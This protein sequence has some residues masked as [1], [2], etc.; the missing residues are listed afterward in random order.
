MLKVT[1]IEN[2]ILQLGPGE[3]Q[4]FC[5]TF[6]SKKEE[7]G[8]ILG[9]GTKS[10]TSKTTK[11]NPDT[12]FRKDNGKYVFVAY[13]AQQEGVNK[14]IKEDIYKCLDS[15]K[16]GVAIEDI[17]EIVCCH[18]SSTLTAGEDKQLHEYCSN[19]GVTLTFYGVDEIAQEICKQ[20]PTLA[21]DLGISLDTHQIMQISDFIKRYDSNEM[22]APLNTQFLFRQEELIEIENAIQTQNVVVIHGAAG[23]GKTRIAIE[24]SKN[25]ADRDRYTLLCVKS[26][27]LA[28]YEDLI[29]YTERPGKYLFFIDDANE[30]SGLNL[31]LDYINRTDSGYHIKVILTV[32]DYVKE[33]VLKTVYAFASPAMV[34]IKRLKDEDIK[35]FL[36]VNMDIRNENYV[37]QIVRVAEGNLRIA[38]MTG[39]LAIDKAS[40]AAIRD[41]TD[42]YEQYYSAIINSNIWNSRPLSI[43][44]GILALVNAVM[45]DRLD[46]FKDLLAAERISEDEFVDCIRQLSSMELVEVHKDMVAAVSDQ[47][48]ANYMLYYSFF[49]K[50]D[51]P[52]STVLIASF[53]RFKSGVVK[54]MNTLLNIFSKA[55]VHNYMAEEVRIA[56]KSFEGNK[57]PCFEDFARAFHVFQPEA[58]FIIAKEKIDRI[59]QEKSEGK[60][61][62]FK[63]GSIRSGDDILGFLTG[64]NYSPHLKTVFELLIDFAGKSE[65]NALMGYSWLN[66]NYEVNADTIKY[67][68]YAE[69]NLLE[70]IANYTDEN[71][72]V[73]QLILEY[74]LG[75]LSF[76]FRPVSIGRENTIRF[77]HLQ[78]NNSEGVKAYRKGCWNTLMCYLPKDQ[79]RQIIP[80]I[81]RYAKSLRGA[82]DWDIVSDDKPYV[83]CLLAKLQCPDIQKAQIV[84][85]LQYAWI[86][87][88]DDS[89]SDNELFQLDEWKLFS[90]LENSYF[91]ADMS[92]EE[93]EAKRSETLSQYAE[94]L[95]EDQLVAF[96]EL[97][98]RLAADI[99]SS[100]RFCINDGVSQIVNK[101]C[102][103]KSKALIIFQLLMEKGHH[104]EVFPVTLYQILFELLSANEIW[105]L[106]QG[107]SFPQKNT[108]EY[109]FFQMLP[110]NIINEELYSLVMEYLEKDTD[111]QLK[112]SPYRSMRFLDKFTAIHREAYVSAARIIF[113]KKEYSAFI[114][115]IYFSM[116]FHENVYSPQE[117][118]EFFESD[119]T[120]LRDIYMWMASYDSTFDYKGIFLSEYITIDDSWINA[121]ATVCSDKIMNGSD[122]DYHQLNALW[123]SKD[124]VYYIDTIFNKV[125]ERTDRFSSWRV[126]NAF[127]SILSSDRNKDEIHCRKKE[128]LMH[129]VQ[130]LAHNDKIEILFSAISEISTDLRK[131]AFEVFLSC[132]AEYDW[133]A[134]LPLD[135]DHWGGMEAAIIPDLQNRIN[136]LNSLLPL[137][138][139][140]NFLK[141][142]MRI[143]ERIEMWKSQIKAEE[144]NAIL[145]NVYA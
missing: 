65:E 81:K 73:R 35:K 141:H 48:F 37:D 70:I 95:S 135:P 61:L 142:S 34:E 14:K 105:E 85:D 17:E 122:R 56:W 51:I 69:R 134:K 84:R 75:L 86:E 90:I 3:F 26:N 82:E 44:A 77:Y 112:S 99:E 92:Y 39:K 108:W 16:T 144:M 87:H 136:F 118:K 50:K 72:Y 24:V 60:V 80:F 33:G 40:L 88:G 7:Y 83:D 139:G 28:L 59:P 129:A 23:V 120:L 47:C 5:D 9:L 140:I 103:D 41:V 25:I 137:V 91:Y 31:I 62:D 21:E 68:F 128:W 96:I 109:W 119:L 143:R 29:A 101:L 76:E 114:V 66:S 20:Y 11:G 42:V 123:L 145:R 127:G 78:L 131:E 106:I 30:L 121:Y 64:Y 58:A 93:Y 36:D 117:V 71:E 15:S 57:A 22:A 67:D 52:F 12:Y 45:L 32:R 89:Y 2:A 43:T 110:E 53:S 4:K 100:E 13:T 130:V 79:G 54:A 125:A 18:T 98:D 97:A 49:L 124:Y 6:L 116:L 10:G 46:C 19:K 113:I 38:Y 111:K 115:D 126:A 107:Q 1:A 27:N 63:K 8:A 133:F 74:L 104:L 102:I 94:S 55:D 138:S 132:N